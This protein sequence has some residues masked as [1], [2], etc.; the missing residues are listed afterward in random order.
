MEI[1]V[2]QEMSQ[3]KPRGFATI[4]KE[5]LR[6]IASEA[7]KKAHQM[8]LAHKFQAGS[9]EAID[10]GKK[11]G[12]KISLNRGHMAHIGAIGGSRKKGTVAAR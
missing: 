1:G 11:G 9:K 4:S 6:I 8:G 7:G 3:K 10:A 5:R 2:E 12:K